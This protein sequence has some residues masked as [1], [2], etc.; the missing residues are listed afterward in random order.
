MRTVL[1]KLVLAPMLLAAASLATSTAAAQATVSV[2][3]SFIAAG[4]TMPAGTY[5]LDKDSLANIVTLR[6]IHGTESFKWLLGP[7]DPAPTDSNVTMRFDQLDGMH[8]LR[9]IQYAWQTT[10][11]LD[12]NTR[13]S[14]H[15]TASGR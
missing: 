12:R 14:E 1:G 11:R 5:V 8:E 10:S 7:G 15:L 9:S 13:L 4:R 2:P 3:F 6:N